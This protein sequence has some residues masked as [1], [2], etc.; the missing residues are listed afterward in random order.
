MSK[1]SNMKNQQKTETLCIRLTPDTKNE[2]KRKSIVASITMTEYLTNL[3]N[4][5]G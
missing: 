1:D 4:N 2:L 5:G 3:I